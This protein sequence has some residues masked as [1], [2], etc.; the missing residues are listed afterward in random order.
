MRAISGSNEP[1]R[2]YGHSKLSKMAA[3]RQL[4]FDVTGNSA[5]R[6]ANPENPTQEPNMKCI[7]SPVA[8]I[9]P[10]AY[11]WCIWN[12]ILGGRGGRRWSAMAPFERAMVV[13][14]SLSIVTVALSVTLRPQFAIKCLRRSNQQGVGHFGP[15]F[16]GVPLGVDPCCLGL[17]RANITG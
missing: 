11:L 17:Q 6:S 5:I 13:S 10:F 8:E 2:R 1:L 16:P 3:C 12:L 7:G 14:Y 15:K 9:W 4:G